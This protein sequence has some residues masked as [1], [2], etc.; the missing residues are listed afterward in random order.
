MPGPLDG[1]RIFDMT[2]ILAGPTAT[3]VL[4]DLGAD[5]I[6]VERPGKG[7][8]VRHWGPPY[9]TD[10]D[11]AESATDSVYFNAANRNKRS[12]TLNL[13]HPEG[14]ALAKRLM[15][16]CD[17]LFEN[18]KVGDLAK[19]SLAYDQIKAEFPRLIY[20]SLTGFGQTGPYAP[21]AGFDLVVQGMGG[22]MSITGPEDGAPA[23]VGVGIADIMTGMYC[24]IAILAA[25]RHRDATG[26][27]Q[28]IDMALLDCQ[29]AWLVNE[30]MNYLHTGTVPHAWGTAH[31]TIVPYQAFPTADGHFILAVGND[32]QYQRFCAFA[33]APGL[34]EDPRFLTNSLRVQH[35]PECVAAVSELTR[36]HPTD[37]WLE[38]L[39]AL[40]VPCGPVNT[41]DKVFENPQVQA[42]GMKIEMEHSATGKSEPY[43]G[44]PIKMSETPVSYRRAPPKLGEH[45]EDVLGEMLG[46]DSAAVA[47][48]RED[49]VV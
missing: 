9:L 33:G 7:D 41:I 48:L 46:M 23:K 37:H 3:Q 20:C 17:V 49:G 5:V 35:R 2:R 21:R 27:G 45:T 32:R 19:Y 13:A 30:G 11:G 36:R 34:A 24:N 15:G 8:D 22:I 43:I 42:R 10:A 12:I 39:A 28:Q 31:A 26:Q 47:K 4:A 44:S 25:L 40:A 14:Q 38:G 16:K 1:L 6:K 18:Y 29:V